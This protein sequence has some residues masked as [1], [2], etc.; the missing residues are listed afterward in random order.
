MSWAFYAWE[1]DYRIY[2]IPGEPGDWHYNGANGP[3][4]YFTLEMSPYGPYISSN[5]KSSEIFEGYEL[6]AEKDDEITVKQIVN[7]MEMEVTFKKVEP[8]NLK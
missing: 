3:D 4:T 1:V 2:E 6:I 8:R 5:Y 7:G